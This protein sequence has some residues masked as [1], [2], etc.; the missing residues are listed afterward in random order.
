[1]YKILKYEHGYSGSYGTIVGCVKNPKLK[2][3]AKTREAYIPLFFS[4]AEA[5]RFDWGDV[6]VCI[7]NKLVTLQL[8]VVTLGHSR[9]F[10]HVRG[11][12]LSEVGINA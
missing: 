3:K 1:M 7:G 9:R 8:A 6:V 5:F 10:H 11:L 12:S 4:Q 2:L